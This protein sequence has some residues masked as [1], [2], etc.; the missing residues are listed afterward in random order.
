MEFDMIHLIFFDKLV[1]NLK[2]KHFDFKTFYPN[3]N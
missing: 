1:L 3:I 2:Q